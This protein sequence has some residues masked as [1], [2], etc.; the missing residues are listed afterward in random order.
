MDHGF[1]RDAEP[2]EFSDGIIY[3]IREM[4]LCGEK[5]SDLVIDNF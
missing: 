1:A 5:A 4:S 3:L 2:W